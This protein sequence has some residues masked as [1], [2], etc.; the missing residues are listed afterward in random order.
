MK[1]PLVL[2]YTDQSAKD[3]MSALNDLNTSLQKLDDILSGA[4]LK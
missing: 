3:A 1:K 4:E 2:Y